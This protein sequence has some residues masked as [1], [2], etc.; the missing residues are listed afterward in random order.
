MDHIYN[1][2]QGLNNGEDGDIDYTII[3]QRKHDTLYRVAIILSMV[4]GLIVVSL[5]NDMRSYFALSYIESETFDDE[6]KYVDRVG[7]SKEYEEYYRDVMENIQTYPH[8]IVNPIG[9]SSSDS[10]DTS[11]KIVW[12]KEIYEKY[13]A[14]DRGNLIAIQDQLNIMAAAAQQ[15]L[16]FYTDGRFNEEIW[17]VYD[18][19]LELC[20]GKCHEY[21]YDM[22]SYLGDG[23]VCYC[24][25]SDKD[26]NDPIELLRTVCATLY[27]E[28][29]CSLIK[30]PPS[31]KEY[32]SYWQ[33]YFYYHPEEFCSQFNE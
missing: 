27:T 20:T 26:L 11:S 17:F 30:M 13:L 5:F 18:A 14:L 15:V 21:I 29:N 31:S 16:D 3:Y 33:D 28:L 9:D 24:I 22:P 32:W 4:L 8:S 23:A 6:R 7:L 1:I 19:N 2:L 10:S 12:T 25:I